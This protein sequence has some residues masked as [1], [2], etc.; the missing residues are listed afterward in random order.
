M[1]GQITRT[2]K[3]QVL[4][5]QANSLVISQQLG[6]GMLYREIALELSGS[7]T[8]TGTTNKFSPSTIKGGDEWGYVQKIELVVNGGDTIRSFTGEEFRM[9]NQFLFEKP[10]RPS[11]LFNSN[12]ST[13]SFDSTLILPF[14]DYRGVNP[15]DTLLD[16]SKLSD[17]RVQ[18]TWGGPDS[19]TTF[20]GNTFTV[21]PT[22]SIS[23]RESYGL[24]GRFAVTRNF[25]ITNSGAIAQQAQYTVQLPL[26]NIYKGFFINT[27]NASG[28]DLV[29]CID[30]VQIVSGTNVYL[31]CDY[32]CLRDWWALRNGAQIPRIDTTYAEMPIAMSSLSLLNGWQYINLLDDGYLTEAI[33]TYKLSELKLV[34]TVN[35]TIT[36]MV[37]IPDQIIP[38]RNA[39]KA[40][41]AK[42]AS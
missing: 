40:G 27:K 3:Q 4:N 6:L 36:S 24:K 2:R 34:F 1:P 41:T 21:A 7:I 13:A 23:S 14:W 16:S 29:D 15:V 9:Y 12:A 35:Q 22:I 18:I 20:T 30:H 8:S 32:K 37:I 26:G 38:V 5:Y 31:D 25:R 11:Q 39:A 17:M 33:D 42:T 10:P 19:A 28:N